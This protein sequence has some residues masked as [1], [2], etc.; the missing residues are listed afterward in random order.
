MLDVGDHELLFDIDS[1]EDL[2]HA[3]AILDGRA[4]VGI[5]PAR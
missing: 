5:P 1:P 2:L 3:A 4:R